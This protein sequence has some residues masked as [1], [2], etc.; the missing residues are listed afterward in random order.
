MST[1]NFVDIY[2]TISIRSVITR[3]FHTSL[4]ILLAWTKDSSYTTQVYCWI[5]ESSHTSL[6]FVSRL[7]WV[8]KLLESL[9]LLTISSKAYSWYTGENRKLRISIREILKDNLS[10]LRLKMSP[11]TSSSRNSLNKDWNTF[12]ARF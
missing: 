6:I 12:W 5:A 9:K 4:M 2:Q 8:A 3:S 1:L 7:S 10:K 11:F